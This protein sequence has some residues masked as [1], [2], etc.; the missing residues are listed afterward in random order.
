MPTLQAVLLRV[1]C[2]IGPV[3]IYLMPMELLELWLVI[4][5]ARVASEA[6]NGVDVQNRERGQGTVMGR[7]GDRWLDGGR[8]LSVPISCGVMPRHWSF[9]PQW[10]LFLSLSLSCHGSEGS[11]KCPIRRGRSLCCK[12]GCTIDCQRIRAVVGCPSA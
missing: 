3:L 6:F 5:T 10:M 7:V 11:N 8:L 12:S 1:C 4:L 9:R 2:I